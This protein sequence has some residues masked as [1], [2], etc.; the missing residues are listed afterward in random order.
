MKKIDYNKFDIYINQ[1]SE[2]EQ[3]IRKYSSSR[4]PDTVK[5]IESHEECLL[6]DIGSNTGSYSL[7]A[8][9]QNL[10]TQKKEVSQKNKNDF[11]DTRYK[12]VA[13]EPHPTNYSSLIKNIY[14]NKFEKFIIPLHLALSD[15]IEVGVLNHWDDYKELEAGSSGHQFNTTHTENGDEFIPILVQP[16]LSLTVDHLVELIGS[17]PTAIKIDVD[18]NEYKIIKGMENTLKNKILKSV[19]IEVNKDEDNIKEIF[20]S[21]GFSISSVGVHNNIVFN[22]I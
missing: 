16:I 17:C 10:I 20:I 13:I 5:W 21:N 8:A 14:Y 2:A 1:D 22:R 15:R 9:S 6:F 18:G 19:L 3:K 12:V 4:E 11:F 7:I